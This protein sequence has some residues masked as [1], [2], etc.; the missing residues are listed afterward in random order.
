MPEIA[1]PV[2]L[3]CDGCNTYFDSQTDLAP[4]QIGSSNHKFCRRCF[5]TSTGRDYA[6]T[7]EQAQEFSRERPGP[8][9][10]PAASSA[11]A[12]S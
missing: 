10:A 4:V 6:H 5:Q 2:Q 1:P 11:R 12:R 9:A 7:F 8:V 3:K